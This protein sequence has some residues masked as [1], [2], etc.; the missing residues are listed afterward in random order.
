[1]KTNS[2]NSFMEG[3]KN[4]LIQEIIKAIMW[5]SKS[6]ISLNE[7]VNISDFTILCSYTCRLGQVDGIKNG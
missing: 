1:M 2:F 6:Y 5:F 7:F 3:L 4:I